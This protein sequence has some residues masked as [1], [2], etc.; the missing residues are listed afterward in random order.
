M[1]RRV[2]ERLTKDTISEATL[3]NSTAE[4]TLT[5]KIHEGKR[6]HFST[7]FYDAGALNPEGY[8]PQLHL[9]S[10]HIVGPA[11][12]ATATWLQHPATNI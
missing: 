2:V 11:R 6:T 5:S 12:P 3:K 4:A 10:W 7:Y 1:D 8:P 9:G